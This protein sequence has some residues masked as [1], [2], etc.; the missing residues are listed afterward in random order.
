[1]K[2]QRFLDR[3]IASASFSAFRRVIAYAPP[4][5]V[6]AL[7]PVTV[8][9]VVCCAR[10]RGLQN[11]FGMLAG[12]GLSVSVP[13]PTEPVGYLMVPAVL[14]YFGVIAA[15][16]WGL[17]STLQRLD[18]RAPALTEALS[19]VFEQY[20]SL[21]ATTR[22]L[23]VFQ[24]SGQQNTLCIMSAVYL[25][26]PASLAPSVASF[27]SRSSR[28][29]ESTWSRHIVHCVQN[30]AVRGGMLCVGM[31]LTLWSGGGEGLLVLYLLAIFGTAQAVASKRKGAALP[32]DK[33]QDC[34]TMLSVLCAQHIVALLSAQRLQEW[35]SI[36]VL[37]AVVVAVAVV[38]SARQ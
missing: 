25:V 5:A 26:L 21:F 12:H 3:C 27:G 32:S 37:A 7:V 9:G 8:L 28:P 20:I 16:G 23:A 2:L 13:M 1:M 29:G 33:L 24:G 10:L 15:A 18:D 31:Q 34:H 30:L 36:S 35:M 11:V 17:D 38:A 6:Q 4:G 19:T 22:A 14:L